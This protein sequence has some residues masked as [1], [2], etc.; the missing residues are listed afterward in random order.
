MTESEKRVYTIDDIAKEL[1]ISKT[2]VSRAISGKG[3]LSKETRA[4]VLEF[5]EAHNFRP[6]AVA[7]SLAHSRSFNIGLILPQAQGVRNV[8][9]FHECTLGICEIAAQHDYDVLL[10]VDNGKSPE[11]LQRMIDNHK[12]DGVVAT[13]A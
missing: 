12:V 7:K 2:T 5:I 10:T 11:Q 6:N 9:F 13:R 1:G 4:K 8:P 3:R